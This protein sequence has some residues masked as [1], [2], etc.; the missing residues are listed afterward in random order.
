MNLPPYGRSV[1]RFV[2][3]ERGRIAQIGYAREEIAE[4]AG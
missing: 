4:S 2:R 3:R 1:K